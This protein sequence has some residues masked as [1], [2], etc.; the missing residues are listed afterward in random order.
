M[1][2]EVSILVLPEGMTIC[3]GSSSD[4]DGTATGP[5]YTLS[6]HTLDGTAATAIDTGLRLLNTQDFP[7]GFAL[8]AK[9]SIDSNATLAQNQTYIRCRTVDSPYKGFYTRINVVTSYTSM[10][11]AWDGN[12]SAGVNVSDAS[13]FNVCILRTD[14][15]SHY[16]VNKAEQQPSTVNNADCPLLIGGEKDANGDWKSDSFGVGTIDYLAVYKL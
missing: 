16:S 11:S 14:H 12:T 10:T 4:S 5:V 1:S 7:H 8:F 13:V 9:I 3:D 15:F 6:D 2:K